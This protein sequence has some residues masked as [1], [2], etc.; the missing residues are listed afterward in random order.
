MH[1]DTAIDEAIMAAQENS[2]LR[3][4]LSQLWHA[5]DA[6][7][8]CLLEFCLSTDGAAACQEHLAAV[9][10]VLSRTKSYVEPQEDAE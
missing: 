4:A 2:Q 8:D 5:V 6:L 9:E 10:M 1:K 7:D 3:M